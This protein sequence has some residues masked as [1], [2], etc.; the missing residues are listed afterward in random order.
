MTGQ[1]KQN[2]QIWFKPLLKVSGIVLDNLKKEANKFKL[3]EED[4]ISILIDSW[5]KTSIHN[6]D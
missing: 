2:S 5:F 1:E 6:S 4:L 3:S